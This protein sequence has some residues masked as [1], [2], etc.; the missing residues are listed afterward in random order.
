MIF[1][2]FF[3]QNV[4]NTDFFA[5]RFNVSPRIMELILSR[6]IAEALSTWDTCKDSQ[7]VLPAPGPAETLK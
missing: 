1:K 2:K 6:G 3:N 5:N 7:C 4:G